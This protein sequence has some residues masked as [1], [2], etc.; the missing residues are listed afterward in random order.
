MVVLLS[1]ATAAV[2]GVALGPY[3]GKETGETALL[4]TLLDRSQEGDVFLGDC[5]FSSYFMLA[6]L[7]AR[8]VDVVV[9]QHQRR[10]TDFRQGRHLGREDQVVLWQR[11]ACP[12]WM[13]EATYA[14]IPETLT[15]RE[16]QVP[17]AIPGF[18]T[19]NVLVATTLTDAQRY[20]K[21]AV[22]ALFRQRWHVELD[23][24]NIKV[25]LHLDDLRGRT[26]EMV[27]RE[28]QVF[29]LAYN[30]LRKVMAQAALASATLPRELSFAGALSAM[31]GAWDH[32]TVADD[33]SLLALARVQH[34]FLARFG[35]G[36]RPNRVEP[37]AIKRRPKQ[38]RLLQQPRQ[39]SR[40]ALL[41]GYA[42]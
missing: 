37:R 9:R 24:R 29:W 31:V 1:L 26:A 8:G 41:R 14:T 42:N 34:R 21:E 7:L 33:A 36:H 6:L 19:K 2:F 35:V 13:D 30:L 25:T 4:R 20:P 18:R 22:A 16:L 3:Q 28:I 12:D 32:A 5:A 40:A 17:V 38:Q 11:P 15:V 10:K 27:R 23:L 39:D